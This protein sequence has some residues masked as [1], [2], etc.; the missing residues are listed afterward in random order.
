MKKNIL[1][2]ALV[3]VLTAG[4]VI[5]TMVGL[6]N[7]VGELSQEMHKNQVDAILASANVDDE[8]MVSV[9]ILY[10]TQ[11]SDECGN[12]YDVDAH[13]M[14]SARQFE[15]SKCG[16]TH[17]EVETELVEPVLDADYLPVGV[18][19]NA[20]SNRGLNGEG[21]KR[22]FHTV[23]GKSQAR[24]A[25]INLVYDAD[26]ASFSY[27]ND[28]F[29]PV[30]D[31]LF[32]FSLG[33]PIEVMGEGKEGFSI[34]ADD[35]TWVYLNDKIVIDMGGVHGVTTGRFKIQENGEVYSAVGDED[36][37]Y[38][39]V[40]LEKGEG[41]IVRIF[42]ADRDSAE[43]V[44]RVKLSNTLINVVDTTLAEA[45]DGTTVAYDPENPDYIAPLGES[46]TYA[47]DKSRV[48]LSAVIAQASVF[49]ALM[50][51]AMIVASVVWRMVRRKEED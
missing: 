35:D 8:T 6:S 41:V 5:W 20:L 24:A 3:S 37:A 51:V 11:V 46:L 23:E 43:S 7:T 44:L 15:W 40:K 2:I 49:G 17:R 12:F 50:V 27:E 16:Y 30:G 31:S 9:P 39:G 42:H 34:S 45:G 32:T 14:A 25:E 47:P 4:A 29:H 36:L 38:S 48:I 26:T 21:F 10:Y 13:E 19:G 22:F 18:G 33:V 1:I 28:E